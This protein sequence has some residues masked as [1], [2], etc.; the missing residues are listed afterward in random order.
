MRWRWRKFLRLRELPPSPS[1]GAPDAILFRKSR[2]GYNPPGERGGFHTGDRKRG[3]GQPGKGGSHAGRDG[4]RR[5]DD[6]QGSSGKSLD[7]FAHP[8]VSG[9]REPASAGLP[10]GS[11]SYDFP[12]CGY[13]D[14]GQGRV[15]GIREMRK[16][17]AWYTAGFPNSA[18]LRGRVNT[19]ETL[20][21][22]RAVL[23]I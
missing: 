8:P 15:H 7:F 21:E 4:L 23:D 6:R 14:C 20:E 2:L 12:P 11:K 17:V 19:V 16:H 22:L 18:R 9:G 1:T 3:C 5:G 10:A 13:V